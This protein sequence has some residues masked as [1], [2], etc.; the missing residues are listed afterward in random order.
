MGGWSKGDVAL[1]LG[2][3]LKAKMTIGLTS[4]SLRPPASHKLFSKLDFVRGDISRKQQL[5]EG[6]VDENEG[7]EYNDNIP[8][9]SHVKEEKRNGGWL[10]NDDI[11]EC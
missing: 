7:L 5:G 2:A 10:E 8:F 1:E 9:S 4:R 11:E 3:I 6:D